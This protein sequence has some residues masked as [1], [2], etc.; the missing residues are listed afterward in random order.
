[1]NETVRKIEARIEQYDDHA[2]G[3]Q[4]VHFAPMFISVR[5]SLRRNF[6]IIIRGA[7]I[8]SAI[9]RRRRRRS[10]RPLSLFLPPRQSRWKRS[11]TCV[12][13]FRDAKID[14]EP[15]V[16]L[17]EFH[18]VYVSVDV[19]TAASAACQPTLSNNPCTIL[20]I[21]GVAGDFL[22][23]NLMKIFIFIY[24]SYRGMGLKSC[25]Y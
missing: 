23:K 3:C 21:L 7:R 1:M 9:P 20:P 4:C 15:C 11:R 22:C 5:F 12:C 16:T 2:R 8:D 6:S 24:Y 14:T 19:S 13:I 10:R 17:A 18:E 25:R